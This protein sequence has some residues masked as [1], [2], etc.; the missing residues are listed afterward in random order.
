MS[1]HQ[2]CQLHLSESKISTHLL[3][4]FHFNTGWWITSAASATP[5]SSSAGISMYNSS[6]TSHCT[7][8]GMRGTSMST[9]IVAGNAALIREYFTKGYY[10]SGIAT[11]KDAFIP[12]G[13]LLKA[14]LI[15][16]ARPLIFTVTS[17]SSGHQSATPLATD[18]NPSNVQGFGRIQLNNVLN[19][20]DTRAT[21]LYL[22][23]IGAAESSNS[24]YRSLRNGETEKHI[25]YTTSDATQPSIRIT[26]VYT[27][28]PG[29][30]GS[31]RPLVNDL[32]IVVVD[33]N[34]AIL[35]RP[36]S[37]IQGQTN[38]NN[39]QLILIDNPLPST[40]YTVVVSSSS[41]LAYAQSYS[42]VMTGQITPVH[43]RTI[44]SFIASIKNYYG[45][46]SSSIKIASALIL[47]VFLLTVFIC[48][49]FH[50]RERLRIQKQIRDR[51]RALNFS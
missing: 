24:H 32:N 10:P 7:M 47:F 14:M 27:D 46:T 49:K 13:A 40:T 26:L 17:D 11:T 44:R 33:T 36:Q 6:A 4:L 31:T 41:T 45:N 37:Y 43:Q 18:I 5:P 48:I 23:I 21:P 38:V 19:F 35:H 29:A 42:L 3:N 15:H 39:V 22:F 25:F 16:S 28:Y 1:W 30:S 9:P 12:S 50:G 2:V 34:G 51:R 20:A 8:K